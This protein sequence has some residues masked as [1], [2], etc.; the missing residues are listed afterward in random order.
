MTLGNDSTSDEDY[1]PPATAA[2]T[3]TIKTDE[4]NEGSVRQVRSC[5]SINRKKIVAKSPFVSDSILS[6]SSVSATAEA[7]SRIDS[8]TYDD[9]QMTDSPTIVA[10]KVNEHLR[11][12]TTAV[13]RAETTLRIS[14]PVNMT[15]TSSTATKR[16]STQ[17]H[18]ETNTMNEPNL[19]RLT[20]LNAH[21]PIP[22]I[23]VASSLDPLTPS[24]HECSEQDYMIPFVRVEP[25]WNPFEQRS[26]N[27][28]VSTSDTKETM[29]HQDNQ[30]I[31]EPIPHRTR[32]TAPAS[33]DNCPAQ[34]HDSSTHSFNLHMAAVNT[35]QP[36]IP[37]PYS[38][39]APSCMSYQVSPAALILIS[40]GLIPS[41]S[42]PVDLSNQLILDEH[43]NE[44]PDLTM[45]D[46]VYQ[47]TSND[48]RAESESV[49]INMES[50]GE[51]EFGSE[52]MKVRCLAR[53]AFI[54]LETMTSYGSGESQQSQ[55]DLN[56]AVHWDQHSSP[57]ASPPLALSIPYDSSDTKPL[58]HSSFD[59]SFGVDASSFTG[60]TISIHTQSNFSGADDPHA[61][62][63]SSNSSSEL[64]FC[65]Y[66]NLTPEEVLQWLC[67]PQSNHS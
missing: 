51:S 57:L 18:M 33:N 34:P 17:I 39:I 63:T 45:S 14:D 5:H 64:F 59:S 58:I 3:S 24:A 54:Q 52:R 31:L 37:Q 15:S 61:L 60:S 16:T 20:P 36:T 6:H 21:V 40:E 50:S 49:T 66:P 55:L 25:M 22:A 26:V 53:P 56:E 9:L 67:Q 46:A 28:P 30:A 44:L 47:S 11:S 65:E 10:V 35:S 43:L 48:S 7:E 27:E 2:L 12:S 29:N 42:P 13:T 41:D 32:S 38:S 8:L 19:K 4:R 23:V 62:P 1:H